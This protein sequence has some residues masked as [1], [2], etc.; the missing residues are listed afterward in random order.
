[1]DERTYG[2]LLERVE[3]LEAALLPPAG[4][5]AGA[6]D[7]PL[8]EAIR[9]VESRLQPVA[10]TR[11]RLAALGPVLAPPEAAAAGAPDVAA[12]AAAL[13]RWVAGADRL[14]ALA[15]AFS[16][17]LAHSPLLLLRPGEDPSAAAAAAP[18]A[19]QLRDADA[20]CADGRALVD[21]ANALH[22]DVGA[23]LDRY[24]RQVELLNAHFFAAAHAASA[25]QP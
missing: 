14:A 17:A 3:A 12:A 5:G 2:L 20:C 23:L 18:A 21:R 13:A 7:R 10:G 8:M 1:M 15:A 9:D 25:V 4:A 24:A 16:S 11:R 22:R 19:R 6:E